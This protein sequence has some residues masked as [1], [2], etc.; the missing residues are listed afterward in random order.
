MTLKSSIPALALTLL[1]AV[2]ASQ[3]MAQTEHSNKN[4][5]P[6]A[7]QQMTQADKTAFIEMRDEFRQKVEPI[8]DQLWAKQMEYD[9]L[10]GNP[11]T[12]PDDIRKLIAEMS[13]L[14]AKIKTERQKFGS[15]MKAKDFGPQSFRCGSSGWHSGYMGEGSR[16][17]YPGYGHDGGGQNY[18]GHGGWH[19]DANGHMNERRHGHHGSGM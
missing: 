3:A 11:N 8:R 9:A 13:D 10:A 15:A 4:Y 18:G 12:K 19:N 14:R 5:K 1:M 6:L 7:T 2:T 17:F 16:F